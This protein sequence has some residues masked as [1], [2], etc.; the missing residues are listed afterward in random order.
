M[1]LAEIDFFGFEAG[2]KPTVM[3]GDNGNFGRGC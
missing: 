3:V 2:K 1:N